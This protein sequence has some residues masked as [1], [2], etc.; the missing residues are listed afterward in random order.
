MFLILLLAGARVGV[1]AEIG[2]PVR[3]WSTSGSA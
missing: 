2:S 1:P 3:R